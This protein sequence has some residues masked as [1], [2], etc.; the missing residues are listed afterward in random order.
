VNVISFMLLSAVI[1][2]SLL[3]SEKKATEKDGVFITKMM[4]RVCKSIHR[5]ITQNGWLS[6]SKRRAGIQKDRG[7]SPGREE[8]VFSPPQRP[9]QRQPNFLLIR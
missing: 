2:I 5:I 4:A 3:L 7:P 8:T 1:P 9:L 6:L